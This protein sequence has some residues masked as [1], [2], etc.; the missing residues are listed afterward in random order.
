[1]LAHPQ[2]AVDLAAL[3]DEQALGR[4]VAV[5][6]A[7]GLQ[8]DALLGVN[9]PAHFPADDRLATHDVALHFPTLRDENLLGG[10][11]GADDGAFDLHDAFGGD[12]SHHP[13]P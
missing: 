4:N 3:L 6:D 5:D 12:V 1:I 9:P 8:L 2:H 7:R 11:H 13:H 10:L